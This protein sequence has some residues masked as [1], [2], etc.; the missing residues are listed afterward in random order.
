MLKVLGLFFCLSL[1]QICLAQTSEPQTSGIQIVLVKISSYTESQEIRN[2]I[3]KISGVDSITT[4]S[5]AKELITLRI[6]YSGP[7]ENLIEA[8]RTTF[9][10]R[11]SITPKKLASGIVEI[12][13]SLG[14]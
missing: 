12:N 3:L 2:E 7:S 1:Q 14:G 9:Q 5:E 4:R 13:L 10:G 6:L 11:Y 8:L